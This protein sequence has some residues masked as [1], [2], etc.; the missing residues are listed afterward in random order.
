M[1]VTSGTELADGR[2]CGGFHTMARGRNYAARQARCA[3]AVAVISAMLACYVA[4]AADA[5][6]AGDWP[7]AAKNHAATRYA[8]LPD[9]TPA[10]ASTLKVAFAFS[11]GIVRGHE[12]AP[13]V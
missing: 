3:K 2:R 8:D 9:I 12:A 4:A 5:P 6:A 7:M 11:T 13:I 10:N 1:H